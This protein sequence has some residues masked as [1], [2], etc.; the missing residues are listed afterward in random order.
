MT[1]TSKIAAIA[2]ATVSVVGT[3]AAPVLASDSAGFDSNFYLSQLKYDG[4][5][6][7]D[8]NDGWNGNLIA[9]VKLDSGKTV[10]QYFDK[11]SLQP[12]NLG[13]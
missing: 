8:V 3:V 13:R 11:D 2:L 12:I 6:V 5:N 4:I 10:F 9:T 1:I 7:I